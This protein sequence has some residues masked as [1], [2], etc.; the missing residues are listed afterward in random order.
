MCKVRVLAML[1]ALGMGAGDSIAVESS[2]PQLLEDCK[3]YAEQGDVPADQFEEYMRMCLYGYGVEY[4]V[5]GGT[6]ADEEQDQTEPEAVEM[7]DVPKV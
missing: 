2:D 4:E 1:A 6:K 5:P 7:E 3:A